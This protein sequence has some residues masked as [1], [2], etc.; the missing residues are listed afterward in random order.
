MPLCRFY[1]STYNNSSPSLVCL[2]LFLVMS[3]CVYLSLPPIGQN[4]SPIRR[5]RLYAQ[6]LLSTLSVSST[7][8]C[9][10]PGCRS[11][12]NRSTIISPSSIVLSTM[13][14]QGFPT[15]FAL[16]I[17]Y[18]SFRWAS[19]ITNI[20]SCS[21]VP[22]CLHT[23]ISRGRGCTKSSDGLVSCAMLRLYE[24]RPGSVWYIVWSS[25]P[26]EGYTYCI[27]TAGPRLYRPVLFES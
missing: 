11:V 1:A 13:H 19:P 23:Q 17:A 18:H 10:T 26:G 24:S 3:S 16:A 6:L 25:D 27:Y 9:Q 2:F 20:F 4:P 7:P 5:D 21:R 8:L 14:S 12:R 15:R 22:P